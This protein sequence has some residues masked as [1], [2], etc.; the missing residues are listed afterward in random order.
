MATMQAA[1]PEMAIE[2]SAAQ[3]CRC[4]DSVIE[5][6]I[7]DG[8]VVELPEIEEILAAQMELSDGPT[9]VM[10][11]ARLVK[12]MTRQAQERTA[13]TAADRDTRAVAILI[14]SPVSRL[15]GNFFLKLARPAYPTRLFRE[16]ARARTWLLDHLK[17]AQADPT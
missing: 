14:E 1:G 9:V 13:N 17:T 4:A 2:T 16:P 15:L 11:D 12:S 7:R 3:I 8:A 5:V 6:R 10:V